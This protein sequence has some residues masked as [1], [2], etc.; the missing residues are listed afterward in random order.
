MEKSEGQLTEKPIQWTK[1]LA[2]L[3]PFTHELLRQ[4]LITDTSGKHGKPPNAH[5][6]K[7]YG[8]Q[9]F[10]DKLV[11]QVKVKANV[12]KGEEYMMFMFICT[13]KTG[14]VSLAS[15]SCKAG[16]GGCCKHVAALLF[17]LLDFIQLE[18]TEVPDDLT[19]TQLLQQWHVPS[20]EEMKTA[21][22]VLFDQVKFSKTTSQHNTPTN[23][24]YFNPSPSFAREVKTSDIEQLKD[25]LTQSW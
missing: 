4:H 8:Y 22:P 10:K 3:P 20:G 1:S 17:Q 14:K 5:K 19:C 12:K 21:I 7:K 16:L 15:C 9:L 25:G 2:N 6:H 24:E 11:A 13:R 18:A 23:Y